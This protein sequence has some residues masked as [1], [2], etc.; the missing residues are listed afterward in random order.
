[1]RLKHLD[2]N[3][4]TKR[5]QDEQRLIEQSKK[6]LPDDESLITQRHLGALEMHHYTLGLY[7]YAINSPLETIQASLHQASTMYFQMIQ[8]RVSGRVPLQFVP[9]NPADP[10]EMSWMFSPETNPEKFKPNY[11]WTDSCTSL[12]Y[13]FVAL[14]A[15]D[16][17]LAHQIMV[18]IWDPE[19]A[20]YVGPKSEVCTTTKQSLAY[21][22]REFVKND[23]DQAKHFLG[24]IKTYHSFLGPQKRML[25]AIIQS[26]GS[27]FLKSLNILL[28]EHQ[29][30]AL[31]KKNHKN[32]DFF[33]CLPALGLSKLALQHQVINLADLPENNLF[34]SKEFLI[35]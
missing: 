22:L 11:A 28:D 21:A 16:I 10:K 13:S 5:M 17:Q 18:N 25:N 12:K 2:P 8:L 23:V 4:V 31:K 3:W 34:F 20:V 24:F 9:N 7:Q 6:N 32:P 26:N 1:M 27:G 30:E 33:L 19:G 35:S 29:E 14:L 15:K